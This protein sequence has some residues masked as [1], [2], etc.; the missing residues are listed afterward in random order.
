MDKSAQENWDGINHIYHLLQEGV[1]ENEL[2][3]E[4]KR[5]VNRP[6]AFEPIVGFGE[7]TAKPHHRG[8]DRPLKKG[9]PVT[10]DAGVVVDGF[11]S[12]CTRS[13][14]FKGDPLWI[15]PI[16]MDVYH[17]AVALVQP[18]VFLSDIQ[19]AVEGWYKE[20]Q[21]T[22]LMKHKIGHRILHLVHEPLDGPLQEGMYIT[23]E[24]GLYNGVGFRYENTLEV[25]NKGARNLYENRHWTR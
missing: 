19:L 17:K 20:Y 15:E 13:F 2:I 9:D 7:N 8:S 25:T 16:V 3:S 11:A 23:I 14:V 5:F 18:G 10:I 22:H 4:Y 21:V 24:P 1:T 12:D 6:L